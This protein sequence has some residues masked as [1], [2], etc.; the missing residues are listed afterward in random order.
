MDLTDLLKAQLSPEHFL[1]QS[2]PDERAVAPDGAVDTTTLAAHDFD[3]DN[4]TGFMPPQPPLARLPIEYEPWET[5]LE[6]AIAQHLQVGDKPGLTP[7]EAAESAA[8]RAWVAEMPLLPTDGLRRSELL[9]RRAHQV[10]AWTLHFYVHTIPADEPILI[11]APLGLPLLRVSAVLQ[12]PPVLTYSD[13]VLYNWAPADP[14][15][16]IPAANNLRSNLLFTGTR[17]EEEF[18]LTSARMELRGVEALELMRDTLDE[19]FVGD[20]LAHKRIAAYMRRLALVIKELETTLLS[21]RDGCAPAVFFHEARPWMRGADSGAGKRPW[22]FD[23]LDSAPDLEPPTELSGPSAG[24]SAL[25][26][27]LDVFLGLARETHDASL[28][29]SAAAAAD[30]RAAFL[31]R[32]Q[33]YMPRHH[34]RFLDHLA[35]DPRPLRALVVRARDDGELTA[36][37]NAAVR[38]MKELRDVHMVIVTMY[39]IQPARRAER[40]AREAREARGEMEV[41]EAAPLRGTGGTELAQFLKG[42]RDRTARGLLPVAGGQ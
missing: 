39:I 6:G 11:P 29:G 21:V 31:R 24:Q 10:L 19:I 3:V 35:A 7:L 28:A 27:A 33:Q 16:P 15:L 40:E 9:L 30:G 34:R 20:E 18:Y 4:R 26:H 13:T 41:E 32:M 2:R 42:V 38:A 23:G 17:D 37:Y 22:V 12:L 36:A 5:V 8:W 25:I 1:A 14:A